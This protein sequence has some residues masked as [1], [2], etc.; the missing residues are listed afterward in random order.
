MTKKLILAAIAGS[1]VQFLLGWIV[2][3]IL[4]AGFMGSHMK[5][6]DGLM[7]D[8]DSGSFM[9]LVYLSGLT[10]SLFIAFVFQRW[11]KF[12]KFFLGLTGGMVIGFF[13]ALSY[14]LFSYSSMNLVEFPGVIVDVIANTCIVGIVGAVIAGVLGYGSRAVSPQ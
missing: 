10:M 2:Y 6:Y 3:G 1:V 12:E 14:D 5:H 13:M 11:A 8:M 4:L 7:K 9:V